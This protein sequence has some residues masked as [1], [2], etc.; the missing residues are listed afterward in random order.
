MVPRSLMRIEG[1]KVWV[2]GKLIYQPDTSNEPVEGVLVNLLLAVPSYPNFI[3]LYMNGETADNVSPLTGR[4][5]E[6]Q[7]IQPKCGW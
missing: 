1:V 2:M 7:Y 4:R 3:S 5:L 6:E